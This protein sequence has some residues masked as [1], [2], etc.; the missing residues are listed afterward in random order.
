MQIHLSPYLG[1]TET[2]GAVRR[3]LPSQEAVS[4]R[5]AHQQTEAGASSGG[6]RSAAAPWTAAS[7]QPWALEAGEQAEGQETP[8]LR[9]PLPTPDLCTHCMCI[10]LGEDSSFPRV[11]S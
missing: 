4:P 2:L 3:H 10:V 7:A 11:P 9:L 1:V 6:S 8:A 5:Q